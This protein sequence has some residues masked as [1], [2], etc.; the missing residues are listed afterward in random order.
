MEVEELEIPT[1]TDVVKRRDPWIDQLQD[2]V[3]NTG[4]AKSFDSTVS[5]PMEHKNIPFKSR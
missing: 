1:L 3:Y 5:A 4:K 2:Q